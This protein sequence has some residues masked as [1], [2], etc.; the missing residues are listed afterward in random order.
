MIERLNFYDVYGYLLPG[1]F[2]LFLFWLPVGIVTHTWPPGELT[3]ALIAVVVAYIAGHLVQ[4]L[5]REVLPSDLRG[6]RR[7]PSSVLL[8]ESNDVLEPRDRFP[9]EVRKRL[10]A[11]IRTQFGLDVS[12][13]DDGAGGKTSDAWKASDGRRQQAFF[14]CRRALLTSGAPSY[15]EQFQGLYAFMRGLAAVCVLTASY[16]IGWIFSGV[17][18]IAGSTM[19]SL[20]GVVWLA[21]MI[22]ADNEKVIALI[23]LLAALWA[24]VALGAQHPASS[25]VR[26]SLVIGSFLLFF[27][28]R[29]AIGAYR[30]F[31]MSFAQTV[32]RDYLVID[33]TVSSPR[34]RRR[35]T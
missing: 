35:P 20:L 26:Q 25:T 7:Y 15:A 3:S 19:A 31:A 34:G 4:G 9:E 6:A 5:I 22:A 33:H 30:R 28:G 8:D 24:G 29:R 13:P 32:Y 10:K 2:L 11:R 23:L 27:I 17:L 18:P 21:A 16:Y 12:D 1:S 14:M